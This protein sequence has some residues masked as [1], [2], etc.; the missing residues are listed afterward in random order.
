VYATIGS[1]ATFLTAWYNGISGPHPRAHPELWQ[2]LGSA[3]REVARVLRPGGRF[4]MTLAS[5][6]A[7]RWWPC[8]GPAKKAYMTYQP[9]HH[10][11]TLS[12]WRQRL[13]NAGLRVT[14]HAWYLNKWA[15]RVVLF[16]DYHISRVVMTKDAVRARLPFAYL[17]RLGPRFW[18]RVWLRLFGRFALRTPGPGG[19]LFLAAERVPES[20]PDVSENCS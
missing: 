18:S 13:S 20:S 16:F 9:V 19:G 17:K 2:D 1:G 14:T 7:Y 10:V 15:T 5:S 12:Q 8:G 6:H 3:L 4:Y 11:L